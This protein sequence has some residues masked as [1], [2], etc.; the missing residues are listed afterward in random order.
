MSRYKGTITTLTNPRSGFIALAGCTRA[1]GRPHDLGTDQDI[2]IH[3]D[4]FSDESPQAIAVGEM[5]VFTTTSDPKRKGGLRANRINLAQYHTCESGI[6][7]HF[8]EPSID[9]PTVPIRWCIKPEAYA[10]MKLHPED[11]WALVFVAKDVTTGTKRSFSSVI[12]IKD[13]ALNRGYV[14]F[15][16][17]GETDL[18]A[19]LI[20]T[21]PD[22]KI[23][24]S[25]INE[26]QKYFRHN[27]LWKEHEDE[28]DL[29]VQKYSDENFIIE[30][31]V[32]V[33]VDVPDG[34]FAKPLPEWMKTWLGYFDMERPQDECSMRG[35][36]MLACTLGVAWY[37]IWETLKRSIMLLYGATH[38]IL[39]GNPL[40]AWREVFAKR[41][42]GYFLSGFFGMRDFE[43][44][45]RYRGWSRLK[46]PAIWLVLA[47]I[48]GICIALPE[49]RQMVLAAVLFITL[50]ISV[51]AAV[52]FGL[53]LYAKRT[54]ATKDERAKAEAEKAAEGA[55]RRL[56]LINTY[57]VCGT[58]APPKKSTSI[59]LVWSAESVAHTHKFFISGAST[60]GC[61]GFLL[62]CQRT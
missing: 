32:H 38:F 13:I 47:A 1:D 48:A 12:G 33:S 7:I 35:R 14:T 54:E 43:P 6:E 55:S 18:V 11:E 52:V 3:V 10:R 46:H 15:A 25:A 44:L 8:D 49:V 59:K 2:F 9:H 24:K 40:V 29:Y 57:A 20:R 58:T 26:I 34:I 17:P 5:V 30:A 61:A 56:A 16:G 41:L 62:S 37:L 36:I 21:E 51:L 45:A 22:K 19:F 27:S 53:I 42:S 50:V 28:I 39:G 31:A 23:T 4:D 60:F